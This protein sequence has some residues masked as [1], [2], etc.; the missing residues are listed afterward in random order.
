MIHKAKFILLLTSILTCVFAASADQ[1]IGGIITEDITLSV[2]SDFATIQ[3]ALDWID[4]R[5]IS[6]KAIVD[7]QIEDGTYNNYQTIVIDLTYGK[8]VHIIGNPSNPGNVV[9]NFSDSTNGISLTNGN[10]LG[11][12]EGITLNAGAIPGSSTGIIATKNAT[13][14]GSNLVINGF[15]RGVLCQWEA[16]IEIPN[17]DIKNSIYMGIDA[18]GATILATN[19]SV[20]G[21]GNN[22][23]YAHANSQILINNGTVTGNSGTSLYAIQ[24]SYI[25]AS[26]TTIDNKYASANSEISHP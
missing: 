4:A 23:V 6:N 16:C 25:L 18:W 13:F 2:P 19:S 12:M 9:I 7:I 22:G 1:P 21:G 20:T 5:T 11:K 8:Q 14:I 3:E 15:Y 24:C 10:V 26:G 17:S